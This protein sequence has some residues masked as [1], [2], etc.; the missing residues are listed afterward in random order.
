MKASE[1]NIKESL[2]IGLL[3]DQGSIEGKKVVVTHNL[4]D[5][6]YE[7]TKK[8]SPSEMINEIAKEA[9]KEI[10]EKK[11]R[12]RVIKKPVKLK[13]RINNEENDGNRIKYASIKALELGDFLLIAE[14]RDVLESYI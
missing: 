7:H 8:S 10:D 12:K 3:L 5:R 6:I 2:R 1:I 13:I 11:K 4:K 14:N 9:L